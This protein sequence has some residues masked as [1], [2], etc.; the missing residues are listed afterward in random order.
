[1]QQRGLDLATGHPSSLG[2]LDLL[3]EDGEQVGPLRRRPL[4]IGGRHLVGRQRVG[5]EPLQHL[6]HQRAPVAGRDLVDALRALVLAQPQ[7]PAGTGTCG[8]RMR[9]SRARVGDRRCSVGSNRPVGTRPACRVTAALRRFRTR[10]RFAAR[11]GS[12]A[13][14]SWVWTGV[15]A[16]DVGDERAQPEIVLG[17]RTAVVDQALMVGVE[18]EADP[19]HRVE[20]SGP[21]P[22]PVAPQITPGPSATG[23][24]G[25]TT[26]QPGPRPVRRCR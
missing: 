23:P 14:S 6:V 21:G 12:E 24:D 9:R 1:M 13:A 16:I 19:D 4:L 10:S 11:I 22:R 17:H 7:H 3:F 18:R 8:G 5:H 20:R 26:P 2:R 25:A 15:V